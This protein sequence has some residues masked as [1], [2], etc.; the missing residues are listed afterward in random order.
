MNG[1]FPASRA[2]YFCHTDTG[3][4]CFSCLAS[5]GFSGLLESSGLIPRQSRGWPEVI[6]LPRMTEWP[7]MTL[8]LPLIA[9]LI[10]CVSSPIACNSCRTL[11]LIKTFCLTGN[12]L[13]SF[14]EPRCQRLGVRRPYAPTSRSVFQDWG[15]TPRPPLTGVGAG[16]GA[17]RR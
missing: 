6:W 1:P 2:C 11:H 5:C 17:G 3:A 7:Q 4:L 13:F 10:A 15:W 8:S 16:G 12:R 14:S 9:T